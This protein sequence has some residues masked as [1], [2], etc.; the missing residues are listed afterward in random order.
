MK[1][2]VIAAAALA[3]ALTVPVEGHAQW[4]LK[5]HGGY[6]LD[7]EEFLIGAGVEFSIPGAA[8]SGVPLTFAPAFDYYPGLAGSS[9]FVMDLDA[10]YPFPAKGMS[11]YVG[12]GMYVS[13][14]SVDFGA[15]GR[16]SDTDVGLN[17]KGGATFGTSSQV[18]PF[19]EARLR[20]GSVSTLTLKAGLS[21]QMGN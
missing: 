20:I 19:T 2:R 9:F 16:V 14:T 17:I 15:F 11:P 5:M 6:D 12:G 7:A 4:S 18:R 3:L 10:H 8:I 1:I 21:I 13:R